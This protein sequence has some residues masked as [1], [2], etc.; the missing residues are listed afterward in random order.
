[1]AENK[2]VVIHGKAANAEEAILM[3]GEALYKEGVAGK[4]F[5]KNCVAREKD[6]PTGLP[7]EIPVAIPHCQDDSVKANAICVLMLEH[8]VEFRRMDDE[9]ESVMTDMLFNLAVMD[10]DEHLEALQNLMVFLN[11]TEIVKECREKSDAELIKCL[12][13]HIG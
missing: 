1:M 8:P 13:E 12:K 3:C 2:Y 5:G 6:F 11:N 10:A 7:T 4:G 9:E